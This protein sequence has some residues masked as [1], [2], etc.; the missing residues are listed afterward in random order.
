MNIIRNNR[1]IRILLVEPPQDFLNDNPTVVYEPLGLETIAAAVPECDV[2]ILDLRVEHDEAA[3]TDDFAPDII[4]FSALAY[5]TLPATLR[6]IERFRCMFPDALTVVG[7]HAT[8][9]PHAFDRPEVDVIVCGEGF[10]TFRELVQAVAEGRDLMTVPGLMLTDRGSGLTSTG[11]RPRHRV[12][13]DTPRPLR[14]LTRAYRHAYFRYDW[15]PV[16]TMLTSRGCPHRCDFCAIWKSNRG[17]YFVRSPEE[18]VAELESIVEPYVVIVDDNFLANT[19]RVRRIIELIRQRDLRKTYL[20][21][22]RTDTLANEPDLAGELASVGV[23]RVL[24]GLESSREEE[25]AERNKSNSV[26]NNERA[27]RL[28]A[29]NGIEAVSYF[30]VRPDYEERDF[31]QLA[32]YVSRL[33]IFES[34]FLML[35]PLPGTDFHDQVKDR[36]RDHDP[37]LYD[38]LH[39]VLPTRLP[40]R[41]FYR[42]YAELWRG[43]IG[44]SRF[45]GT[46]AAAR[47]NERMNRLFEDHELAEDWPAPYATPIGVPKPTLQTMAL[48][49]S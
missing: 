30:I 38:L 17:R 37:R 18:V 10:E 9:T 48:S 11:S 46:P 33:R 25:L 40:L 26:G 21:Y 19:K 5:T 24:L 47:L 8:L 15:R 35:T 27:I 20:V 7:G 28:L 16:A 13:R 41:T 23:K 2:R 32:S 3:V 6:T 43:A 36:I 39:M 22:G 44:Q 1:D 34:V 14:E 31:E 49:V 42:C 29:D 12:A 45:A 4:G